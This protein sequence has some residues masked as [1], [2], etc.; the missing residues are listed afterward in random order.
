MEEGVLSGPEKGVLYQN[1]AK[2]FSKGGPPERRDGG[3][4]LE[5][6]AKTGGT[7]HEGKANQQNTGFSSEKKAGSRNTASKVSVK[8]K[9][10]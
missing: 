5:K 3:A 4:G 8:W 9:A 1:R 10:L 6:K 7:R 2:V